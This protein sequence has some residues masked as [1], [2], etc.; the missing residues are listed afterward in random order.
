[1]FEN[2]L[3]EKKMLDELWFAQQRLDLEI[4]NWLKNNRAFFN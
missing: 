1:M 4:Y 3:N 2:E